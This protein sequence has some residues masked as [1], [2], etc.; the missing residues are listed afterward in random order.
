MSKITLPAQD[1]PIE[2]GGQQMDPLWYE[3]L[4]TIV[5]FLNY[6]S[7][8]NFSTI[9]NGQV[10]VWNAAQKKFLPGAN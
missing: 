4:Q 1:V 9:T 5:T 7:E 8:V 10:L 6:F 2:L 3:K